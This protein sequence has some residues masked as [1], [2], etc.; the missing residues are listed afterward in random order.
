M[1]RIDFLLYAH[2]TDHGDT[3]GFSDMVEIAQECGV[4]FHVVHKRAGDIG[5]TMLFR[6]GNPMPL[7]EV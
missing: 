6:N 7:S 3:I 5:F 1:N 4:S 2:L